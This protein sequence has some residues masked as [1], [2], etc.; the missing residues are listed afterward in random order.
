MSDDEYKDIKDRL[1]KVLTKW[2]PLLQMG[3]YTLNYEYR[4]NPHEEDPEIAA[5]TNTAWTYRRARI[6]WYMPTLH[7]LTHD[8]LENIVL[9]EFCHVILAPVTQDQPPEWKEQIEY[10]TET[11]AVILMNVHR[12]NKNAVV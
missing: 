8:E 6:T 10:T 7:G 4:R 12:G 11:M 3:W 1:E 9:H 2:H 5:V